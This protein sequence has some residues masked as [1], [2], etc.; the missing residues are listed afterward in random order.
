M[1]ILLGAYA[2]KPNAGTEPGYG[3]NWAVHLARRGEKVTVLTASDVR[4]EIEAYRRDHPNPNLDFAYVTVPTKRFK[5]G[6]TA[7]STCPHN[8]G[9]S[10]YLRCSDL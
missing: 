9:A 3:W 8:Y 5:R 2:C 10:G 4:D 7:A 6:S 1:N